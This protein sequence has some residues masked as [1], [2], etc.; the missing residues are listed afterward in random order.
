MFTPYKIIP[1]FFDYVLLTSLHPPLGDGIDQSNFT[2][3][4]Y[5]ARQ[6]STSSS[7]TKHL[8]G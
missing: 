8:E 3:T 2:P 1:T 4:F 5:K 6:Y 7:P